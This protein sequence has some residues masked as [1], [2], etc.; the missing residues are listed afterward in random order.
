MKN[1]QFETRDADVSG[2]DAQWTPAISI[3]AANAL[4]P[5]IKKAWLEELLRGAPVAYANINDHR[6]ADGMA[7][8]WH[9]GADFP[10]MA[11]TDKL[12]ELK[13]M[14]DAATP[15]PWDQWIVTRIL[16]K[17]DPNGPLEDIHKKNA[18]FIAQS[19]TA[20][21]QLIEALRVAVEVLQFFYEFH[22]TDET[23]VEAKAITRIAEILEVKP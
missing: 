13:A 5:T 17:S 2:R 10:W 20:M 21:P 9:V 1:N 12:T 3:D 23:S 22:G 7:G 18:E 19:R 6:V 16:F 8:T 4:L 15:G 11:I 14:A